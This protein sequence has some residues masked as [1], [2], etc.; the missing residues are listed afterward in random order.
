M[1][2]R[3]RILVVD[4]EPSMCRVLSI[5]LK[6]EDCEVETA[7][8][9]TEVENLL[10]SQDFDLLIT[11]MKMPDMSGL[12]V[13]K[14][15]REKKADTRMVVMTAY[16]STDTTIEAIQKGALDYITKEGDYLEKIRKI[17]RERGGRSQ[18]RQGEPALL[19]VRTEYR[20][21]HII[22]DSPA[23]LDICKV[24]GRVAGR[25]STVLLSG[26]SGS[27]K[28][29]IA[30]AI[31]YH[32]DRK[33]HPLIGINCGAL[34]ETLLE[35][36]LFGHVRGSF[37]GAVADKKGLFEASSG[38]TFFLDEIA[39]T[40]KAV[41]VRLLR[42]LQ[43]E[44]VRRVGDSRD[45]E[46]DVRII[47]ATNQ[48][49]SSLI[50]RNLFR[51]DLYFRLNVIPI[52]IPALRERRED[53]PKLVNYFVAKYCKT[54]GQ[55]PLEVLPEATEAL[56]RYRWPGNVRELENVIE[57]VVAMETGEII[58]LASLPDFVREGRAPV[59]EAAAEAPDIPPEGLKL[60]EVVEG[61][62]KEL[63]LKALRMAGNRKSEAAKLLGLSS[64]SFRYRLEK[65]GL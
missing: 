12:E 47:A 20:T 8:S 56:V 30:R 48:D 63:I 5:M 60:E 22:G 61:Y 15:A 13:L 28:E 62:E 51:E 17:V 1:S 23:M 36:E 38:G 58:A 10:Q 64:R 21:D 29:L 34:T 53:I 37:T 50:A 14:M 25:K 55:Y 31:H 35:S 24:I 52:H 19:E 11:D 45:I 2:E 18:E 6:K 26:E 44:R 32:S 65:H 43:E 39:D 33:D 4:D 16:P 7:G 3:T 27:G 9:R 46:V 49:L 57:R 54:S 41:Q 59:A 42:V 40:S